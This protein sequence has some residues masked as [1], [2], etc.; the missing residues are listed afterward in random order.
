MQARGQRRCLAVDVDFVVVAP[1]M[2][3]IISIETQRT[4]T[5]ARAVFVDK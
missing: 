3:Y 5:D 1:H 2:L 4:V